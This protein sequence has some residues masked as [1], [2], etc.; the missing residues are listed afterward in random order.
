MTDIGNKYSIAEKTGNKKCLT[1]MNKI[2]FSHFRSHVLILRLQPF[3][4]IWHIDEYFLHKALHSA[5]LS[6]SCLSNNQWA[7]SLLIKQTISTMKLLLLS[8]FIFMNV[9]PNS[10]YDFKPDV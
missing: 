10:I 3:I 2:L 9:L 1:A 6:L 4:G 8:F 5:W 7:K